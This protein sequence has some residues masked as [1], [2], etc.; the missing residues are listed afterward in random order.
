MI[1]TDRAAHRDYRC[2]TSAAV[3]A[4]SL[5]GN[6]REEHLFALPQA[7]EL[8]EFYR[9]KI[10]ECDTQIERY[11][12]QLRHQTEDDP[13]PLEKGTKRHLGWLRRAHSPLQA[14]GS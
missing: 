9:A 11:L 3:I 1:R 8:Y 2:H 5:V 10:A 6:Y 12:N 13:P 4:Q 14:D 7:V